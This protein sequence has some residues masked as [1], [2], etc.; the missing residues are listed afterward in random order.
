MSCFCS[1]HSSPQNSGKQKIL[2]HCSGVHE[3]TRRTGCGNPGGITRRIGLDSSGKPEKLAA[4]LGGRGTTRRIGL[5]SSGKPEK[6]AA[7]LGGRG[8]TRRIGWTVR[9]SQRSSLPAWRSGGTRRTGWYNPGR[10]AALVWTVR[11]TRRTGWGSCGNSFPERRSEDDSPHCL[12]SEKQS[13]L[14]IGAMSVNRGSRR[15]SPH[16]LAVGGRLAALVG[17]FGKAGGARRTVR[18]SRR[19]RRIG[20]VSC[21]NLFPERR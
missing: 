7:L 8:T 13:P 4:L 12:A 2:A 15:S 20:W 14:C 16:C 10:L 11:E 5:D 18:G 21:G 9:E 17:Q 3:G 1:E 19:T 6:L